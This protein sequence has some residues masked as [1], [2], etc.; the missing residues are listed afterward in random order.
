MDVRYEGD[1]GEP[2]LILTDD[3]R[4]I[5]SRDDGKGYMGLLST[6]LEWNR[7]DPVDALERVRDGVVYY[8]QRHR[9]PFVGHPE[10]A[11]CLFAGHYADHR[12]LH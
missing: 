1:P 2:D 4:E 10:W 3:A 8:F 11:E 7:Q 12:W 9:N 6:L 5:Q